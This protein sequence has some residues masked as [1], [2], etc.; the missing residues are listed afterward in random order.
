MITEAF[1]V[2]SGSV[3]GRY[4]RQNNKNNQDASQVAVDE[5]G[6]I[7]IVSDGCGSGKYS[8]FGAR[9]AVNHLT[10]EG[11]KLLATE[12]DHEVILSKLRF[13]MLKLMKQLLVSFSQ[14]NYQFILDHF[15]F[16]VVGVMLT[17]EQTTVFTL[18]D[19]FISLNQQ[20]QTIDQD[21]Q[22]IYLAYALLPSKI[23]DQVKFVIQKQ[24][25]TSQL[26]S[27]ILATDGAQDFQVEKTITIFGQESSMGK[28]SQFETENRYLKSQNMMQKRLNVL[29]LNHNLLS[30]DT[31]MVLI[32][33][34]QSTQTTS[35]KEA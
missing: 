21:N 20:V 18:G 2:A 1:H 4:H 3:I 27:L 9:L 35:K 33:R 12:S 34:R 23:Q 6:L 22:P 10:A 14:E 5:N 24:I 17:V 7:A 28:L 25:S 30:D 11:L 16:T 15:L 26:E 8:E 19:G 29:G 32:R 31:T 13:S